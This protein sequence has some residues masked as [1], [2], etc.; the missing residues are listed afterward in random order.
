MGTQGTC[1]INCEGK[2]ACKDGVVECNNDGFDCFVYFGEFAGSSVTI[3]GPIDSALEVTCFGDK[4]CE[5]STSINAFDST[6]LTV[7]CFG[8]EACK[9]NIQLNFGY[10]VGTLKCTGEPDACQGAMINLPANADT[11]PGAGFSCRG[12]FCPPDAPAPFLNMFGDHEV[13]CDTAGDCACP[14]GLQGT[15][16][17]NCIGEVDACKD[18]I[19][20]CNN[21]GYDCIVNCMAYEACGG[22]SSIMGPADS[23]LTVNCIGDKSCE[24]A[25][26][27]NGE[28]GTDLTAVCQGPEACKGNAIFNFGYGAGSVVCPGS[29]PDTCLGA[30]FNLHPESP[31]G[32]GISFSCTGNACP[33]EAPVTTAVQYPAG[34][35]WC[36]QTSIANF[37]PWQ[38][39]CWGHTDRAS[40]NAE[41]NDRC[42]WDPTNCFASAPS[43]MTRGERCVNNA[44]CCST[45]CA[46]DTLECR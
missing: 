46:T 7:D 42:A 26:T 19:I 18:G 45:V 8:A 24:G 27:V 15:C 16:T 17:I 33:P 41:A 30:V 40:C 6:D 4:S 37:V 9:G 38:G 3:Q 23:P 14:P 13:T 43:C 25:F 20:E 44:D 34:T 29:S 31:T 28:T 12:L 21:D 22:A 35:Q 2:D 36:C 1:T 32:P 5:G 39:R 11:L 10:G